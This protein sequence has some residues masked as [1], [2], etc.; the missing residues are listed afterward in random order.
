M[1][2]LARRDIIREYEGV[3][4]E[5]GAQAGLVDLS[6]FNIVNAV[7]AGGTPSASDWLLVNAARDYASIAILRGEHLRF[8]RNRASGTDGTFADL[9]HQTA[10]Y[11]EDRLGGAGFERVLLSG[12]G[13]GRREASLADVR[14][15]LED[16]LTR[17]VEFVD[18]RRAAAL[19]DRISAA[20]ALLETLAPLVGLLLRGRDAA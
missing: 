7:L 8:F 9:V 4:A 15:S 12:G 5:I 13:P 17:P 18:P 1:V 2:S 20:P 3:C 16:R 14:R 19:T 11:Y 6:T 10:M